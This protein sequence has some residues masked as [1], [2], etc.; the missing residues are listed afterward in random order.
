MPDEK[1]AVRGSERVA[2][3][4]STVIGVANPRELV[5]ATV[6]V[7]RR[8]SALP[9]Q[10]SRPISREEFA[11]L[12]GADPADVSM[13]EQFAADNDLTVVQ[14]DLSRRSIMLSGTVAHMN[15]AFGTQ[16]RVFQSPQGTYRG[17]TGELSVPTN[18]RDI[19]I[20]VFGLDAR[21]QARACFRRRIE[22][23]GRRAAGDVS[24][25]AEAVAALY[26][27]PTG[28]N[29][30]GQ[31]VAL[32]ELGGGYTASDL[33]A[34]FKEV[35]VKPAPSVTAVSV[36]G[37]LN[38]PV[39]DPNSAD[40]EVL[41]DIE[42]VGAVASGAKIAVYFAPNTDQGFLDAITTAV[43]DNVRQPS[44][45]SISWGGA[46]STWTVQSL[47]AYDQAFQDAGLLGVTV[48]C[49]AGDNGSADNVADGAAHVDF[50][51]SS[52]NVLAC[53][54]TRLES[55]G[56]KISTEVVWNDGAGNGA[57]GGGVS[58]HFPLPAYQASAGVPVSVNSTHFKGRGVP[59]VAGDA[60]P[61]TGYQIHVD[62]KDAV[63]GGT[64]AVA[65]LWAALIALIN[66]QR[67]AHVGFLNPTL[68]AKAAS[69]LSDITAGNN[70]AYK[71]GSGWDACTGLGSPK[72]Q[73]LVTALGGK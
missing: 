45:V 53:G 40:G 72:G 52:P 33:T 69:A 60:D 32:I 59:D 22:G 14:I 67:T 70:G 62:G 46:E 6:V 24:Y 65:P 1:A 55:A 54:G 28:G 41:L 13:V 21:P 2:P 38:Q 42:V 58:D 26:G 51:A 9:P 27:F 50:P 56:G 5:S 49:A 29:G 3:A 11:G 15:E 71:A 63:F 64:S 31:T 25:T 10:G 44:I 37:A 17:R 8:S 61:A 4:D 57:T 30:S 12:Y 36:D 73:A 35:K 43:H 20:G 18:L 39:G 19:V 23:I 48:C 16:L 34:Y 7:R 47:T 68:Y 66:A